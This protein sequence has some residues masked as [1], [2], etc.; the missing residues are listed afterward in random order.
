[1]SRLIQIS[2]ADELAQIKSDIKQWERSFRTDNGRDPSKDDMKE[3]GMQQLYKRYKSLQQSALV[4]AGPSRNPFSPRKQ[5]QSSAV[6]GEG[7]LAGRSFAILDD[8]RVVANPFATPPKIRTGA[9]GRKRDLKRRDRSPSAERRDDIDEDFPLISSASKSKTAVAQTSTPE[10]YRKRLRGEAVPPSP[11]KAN[12]VPTLARVKS[13]SAAAIPRSHFFQPLAA[14]TLASSTTGA[15]AD[16]S[17]DDDQDDDD[18]LN[19]ASPV[20]V[21]SGGRSFQPLFD[22]TLSDQKPVMP[23]STTMPAGGIFARKEPRLSDTH[24]DPS[25]GLHAAEF[26]FHETAVNGKKRPL[27][28][29]DAEDGGRVDHEIDLAGHRIASP[30]PTARPA[31]LPPSPPPVVSTWQPRGRGGKAGGFAQ[32]GRGGS[33]PAKKLR[34]SEAAS[35]DE[36][37]SDVPQL[38]DLEWRGRHG[39]FQPTLVK[40][41]SADA[42]SDLLDDWERD[43]ARSRGFVG[44]KAKPS[45]GRDDLH[46]SASPASKDYTANPGPSSPIQPQEGLSPS[47]A[48][49]TSLLDV[50]AL[51]AHPVRQSAGF[52]QTQD[53]LVRGLILPD[54]ATLAARRA[55]DVWAAGENDDVD[56]LEEAVGGRAA[57]YDSDDDWADEGLR[58][59]EAEL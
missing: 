24:L 13:E 19:V 56:E 17:F 37:D 5:G 8:S 59:D 25:N 57:A 15:A 39:S 58:W 21:A 14:S 3:A 6:Y 32:G 23:R 47:V 35:E 54:G 7:V 45:F 46:P 18:S 11:D 42:D 52:G 26:K 41:A 27:E 50:L 53:E 44:A 55:G 10:R 49:P 43:M 2:P 1:M 38:A 9:G 36:L 29:E 20:K 28:H 33:R 16:V 48:L 34:L 4:S 30:E 40:S 22:E 12:R 31:L 51:D